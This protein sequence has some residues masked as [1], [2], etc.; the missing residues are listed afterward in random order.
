[1]K[2]LISILLILTLCLGLCACQ[3]AGKVE[4]PPIPTSEP[5]AEPVPQPEDDVPATPEAQPKDT[6]APEAEGNLIVTVEK[7]ELEAYDPQNGETLIL[8]FS[9]DTPR[10]ISETAPAAA[11]AINEYLA[12][13]DEAYYTGDDF[14][15][16]YGTGYNNMLTMA[17]DNYIFMVESQMEYPSYEYTADRTATVVRNDNRVLTVCYNDYTYTGGAHGMYSARYYNFDPSTGV[18]LSLSDLSA[19]EPAFKA[20]LTD[21]MAALA[22]TDET[23]QSQID[24]FV[25]PADYDSAFSSLLRDGSW[26]L[27]YDGL[28]VVSDLYEIS[29]YADGL[30]SF[31]IPYDQLTEYLDARYLPTNMGTGSFRV[32]AEADMVDGSTEIIDMIKVFDEGYTYYLVADGSVRDVQISLVE[33]STFFYNQ[34]LLWGC[35]A[36]DDAAVQLVTLI[37][38]GMPNLKLSYRDADGAHVFYLSES[39]L[40][41][42]PLLVDDSIEPVG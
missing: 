37:P 42:E 20:Y 25:D 23:I 16:G 28:T 40:N 3:A 17:E 26:F 10:V 11:Q 4:L 13:L 24:G 18:V 14:G 30:V 15:D 27:G 19:D 34:G 36:M 9:Y 31:V 12:V 6:P 33:Y 2:K 38:E 29:S 22:Q 41:G 7:T 1:M 8:R 21:R 35:S 5:S 39:G 32:L